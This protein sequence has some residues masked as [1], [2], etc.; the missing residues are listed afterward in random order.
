[1]S[2]V[3]RAIA[4][5]MQADVA[6]LRAISQ[7]IANAEVPAY[8]RQIPLAASNFEELL[9][10]SMV[11]AAA[12]AAQWDAVGTD[13]TPGVLKST[14]EPLHLAIEG[15]GYFMLQSDQGALLTRRGDFHVSGDGLLSAASGAAVLGLGGP[16]ELGTATPTVASDGTVRV[17]DAV[18]GQLK[19]VSV[20]QSSPLQYVGDALYAPADNEIT[21][22]EQ[23]SVRQ[24]FL[25]AGNV[26]PVQEMV[27]MMETLRHFE[28]AQRFLLG[29]DQLQQQAISEMGRVDS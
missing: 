18:V 2:E 6:A 19:I 14:G 28:T 26:M 5:T 17:A 9:T 21:T 13:P 3:L 27:R 7:N 22:L 8:R 20:P 10:S 16:I 29:Y 25:E 24:G 23:P 11:D 1:M 4:G 15:D 12:P